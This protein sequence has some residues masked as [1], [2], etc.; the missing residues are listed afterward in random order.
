MLSPEWQISG[1]SVTEGQCQS[2]K[3]RMLSGN[4]RCTI[5]V[6]SKCCHS[7][8]DV[9]GLCFLKPSFKGHSSEMSEMNG[10]YYYCCDKKKTHKNS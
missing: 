3:A 4:L 10:Y 9:K 2:I 8:Q 6:E 1:N 5:K 7:N